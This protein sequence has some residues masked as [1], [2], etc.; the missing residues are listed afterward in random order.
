LLETQSDLDAATC[1]NDFLSKENSKLRHDVERLKV[2][3]ED[4]KTKLFSMPEPFDSNE[5]VEQLK[6]HNRKLRYSIVEQ[7]DTEKYFKDVEKRFLYLLYS[8]NKFK[9]IFN[10]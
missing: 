5:E 1:Q 6:A 10:S 7:K 8:F 4:A 2:Q 9:L 3:L